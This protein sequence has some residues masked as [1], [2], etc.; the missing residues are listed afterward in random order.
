M[1]WISRS[2]E[3]LPLSSSY[4]F[5]FCFTFLYKVVCLLIYP[6]ELLWDSS[7]LGCS[8]VVWHSPETSRAYYSLTKC[9]WFFFNK[10]DSNLL[11]G[12]I[13]FVILKA[14]GKQMCSVDLKYKRF[15]LQT[16][17]FFFEKATAFLFGSLVTIC[18]RQYSVKMNNCLGHKL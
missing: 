8:E 5:F 2:T 6:P 11:N 18:H 15:S 12:L 7:F 10:D 16:C 4:P 1:T 9:I 17:F 3:H 14:N 13:S